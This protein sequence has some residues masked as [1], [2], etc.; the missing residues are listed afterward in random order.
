MNRLFIRRNINSIAIVVF[1]ALFSLIQVFRPSFIYNDDGSF[2][3]FGLGYKHRTAVPIWLVS[4]ILAILSYLFV[5][6]YLAVP[7]M[8]Y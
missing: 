3:N 5:L 6:Y 8:S 1:I 7:K 4:I 2:R